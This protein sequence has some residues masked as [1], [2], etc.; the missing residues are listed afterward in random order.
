MDTQTLLNNLP[1]IGIVLSFLLSVAVYFRDNRKNKQET[2]SSNVDIALKIQEGALELIKP[3]QERTSELVKEVQELRRG[4]K[5]LINQL[6]K[7]GI[8]PAWRIGDDVDK[9]DKPANDSGEKILW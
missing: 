5:V 6:E 8:E 7:A 1:N 9:P 4:I 2:K 3:Y